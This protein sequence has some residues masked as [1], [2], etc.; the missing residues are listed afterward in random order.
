VSCVQEPAPARRRR[1]GLCVG[2]TL[3]GQTRLVSR[4]ASFSYHG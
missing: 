2:E 4:A 1:V 3:D